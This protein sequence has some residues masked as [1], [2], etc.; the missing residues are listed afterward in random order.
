MNSNSNTSILV[1]GIGN[2]LITD[3]G[4][5]VFTIRA[6]ESNYTLSPNINVVD[7]GTL[8]LNLIHPIMNADRVIVA[9]AVKN[10]KKP[11][12]LYRFTLEE[13]QN[14]IQPK[15][16]IHQL[17]FLETLAYVALLGKCPSVTIIGMEPF[18]CCTV[19]I[20]LTNGAQ[21]NIPKLESLVVQEIINCGGRVNPKQEKS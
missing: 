8:G 19:G 13:F 20:G 11:G 10:G 21:K 12:S 6:I 3:D 18:D 9:D 7:G 2:T 15:Q 14:S 1:L 4:I 16:S 17:T 5:G